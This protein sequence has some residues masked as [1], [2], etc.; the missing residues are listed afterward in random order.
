MIIRQTPPNKELY[1]LVDSD[2]SDIL[3][4]YNFY[5]KYIDENGLYYVRSE[6]ILILMEREGLTCLNL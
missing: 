4:G 6:S 2:T 3:H 1:I 5:P